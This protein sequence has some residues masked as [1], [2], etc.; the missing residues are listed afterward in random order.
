[1][2]GWHVSELSVQPLEE[3]D[4][5][6]FGINQTQAAPDAE[7]AQGAFYVELWSQKK[8][9]RLAADVDRG[10]PAAESYEPHLIQA[11][12]IPATNV[13]VNCFCVDSDTDE[14]LADTWQEIS[15]PDTGWAG[16]MVVVRWS[17]EA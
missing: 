11:R 17:Q 14:R 15:L 5:K 3:E 2:N 1:M 16:Q 12:D 13:W 4:S 6:F 8:T 7:T 9:K 10:L